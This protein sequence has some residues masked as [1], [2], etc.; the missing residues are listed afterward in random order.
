MT[1]HLYKPDFKNTRDRTMIAHQDNVHTAMEVHLFQAVQQLTDD[2][3]DLL[4][5]VIQLSY[6]HTHTH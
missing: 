6:T 4:E 2:V 5:S 1:P 3:I